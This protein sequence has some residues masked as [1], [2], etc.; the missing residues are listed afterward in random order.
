MS[1]SSWYTRLAPTRQKSIILSNSFCFLGTVQIWTTTHR[2]SQKCSWNG[3]IFQVFVRLHCSAEKLHPTVCF[4]RESTALLKQHHVK[5]R[6][7]ATFGLHTDNLGATFDKSY[8]LFFIKLFPTTLKVSWSSF[9]LQHL[10]Q[11]KVSAADGN[12]LIASKV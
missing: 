3:G 11:I 5:T 10:V 2:W 6:L 4:W 9:L 8:C 12:N 1:L 7:F